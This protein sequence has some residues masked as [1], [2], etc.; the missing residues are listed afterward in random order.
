MRLARH[1]PGKPVDNVRVGDVFALGCHGHQQV[2]F[3]QPGNQLG[4]P[5]AQVMP[6][7][8][9]FGIDGTQFRVIATPAFGHI[10]VNAGNIEG[11]QFRQPVN[12]A[13]CQRILGSGFRAGQ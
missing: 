3:H 7:A 4:V 13:G 6:L 10:M 2:V 9:G 1:C 12:Q 11:F 8:E 5:F